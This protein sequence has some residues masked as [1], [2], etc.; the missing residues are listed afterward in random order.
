M[1]RLAVLRWTAVAALLGAALITLAASASLWSVTAVAGL[2][3]LGGWLSAPMKAITFLGD[4]YFYLVIIPL[5]FWCLNKELGADLGIL[6][7]A[8]N[9]LNGAVK[10]FFKH[11]RPFWERAALKAVDEASFSLPSAHAQNSA[12]LLGRL[13]LEA[14]GRREIRIASRLLLVALIVLVS[15]SRVY[16]GVH[17][18]GDVIWGA[19]LGLALLA[20]YTWVKPRAKPWL[21]SQP[22]RAHIVLAG[23]TAAVVLILNWALLFTQYGAA[24]GVS[25]ALYD[26]AVKKTLEDAATVSGMIFGMWTGLAFEARY[27]RFSVAGTFARRAAR[28]LIGIITLFAIWLGLKLI[29]PD[30]LSLLALALRTVRYALT[31]FWAVGA[32]PW[33]FVRL[34]LAKGEAHKL[35]P[36]QPAV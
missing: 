1:T 3:G 11:Q 17:F 26:E 10:S 24:S 2:Q 23:T 18:P 34:G 13:A 29:F 31:V 16:L 33:L 5:V 4:E 30:D 12:A 35:S 27:V 9:L 21:S 15:L 22:I 6:L 28:F 19:A 36:A 7:A 8:S 20:A 25:A 32:W 14:P